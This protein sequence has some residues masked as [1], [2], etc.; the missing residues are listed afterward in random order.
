MTV[1]IALFGLGAS[2]GRIKCSQVTQNE[3][4][5]PPTCARSLSFTMARGH[6]W[7]VHPP[8]GW[9]SE[10]LLLFQAH[11]TSCLILTLAQTHPL[12]LCFKSFSGRWWWVFFFGVPGGFWLGQLGRCSAHRRH[13]RP[14]CTAFCRSCFAF[15]LP[16]HTTARRVRASRV[17][18]LLFA[19]VKLIST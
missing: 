13:R 3:L 2:P 14:R 6:A 4:T 9:S 15:T 1:L 17:F 18:W 5:A 16:T 12:F 11:L 10:I 8:P 7:G 19:L